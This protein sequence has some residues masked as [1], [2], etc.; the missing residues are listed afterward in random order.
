MEREGALEVLCRTY[1]YPVY[2]FVRRQAHDSH[3]AQDL[4]QGFF[5]HLL[6]RDVFTTA[7]REK[8]R[9]RSFLL[10]ALKNFLGHERRKAATLRRGGQALLVPIDMEEGEKRYQLAFATQ[11]SPD[12]L[13]LRSWAD[14]LLASALALLRAEYDKA[15]KVA[16]FDQISPRLSGA[17]DE[18]S[19]PQLAALLGMSTGA[20]GTLVYRMRRRYGE[21]L[22]E[23]IAHTV[24][25]PEEIDDEIA[26]L[27]ST[28]A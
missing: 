4:T 9:F 26:F 5:V 17:A 20:V 25:S 3:E 19:N 8:G 14:S 1:W 22:R 2:A 13:Y 18:A 16:L 24:S 23:Q 10:G 7:Q 12:K 28:L 21:L 6:E 27:F 15:G 11:A